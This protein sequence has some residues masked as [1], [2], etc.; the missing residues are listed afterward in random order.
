[1]MQVYGASK[2][3]STALNARDA[4]GISEIETFKVD[5]SEDSQLLFIEVP[6][7]F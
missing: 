6:I 7:T 3:D 5:V 4:V 2:I 1:M